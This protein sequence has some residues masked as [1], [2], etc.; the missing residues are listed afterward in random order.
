MPEASV[1]FHRALPDEADAVRALVVR[2]MGYRD[3]SPEYL[4]EASALMELSGEDLQRDE[5]WMAELSGEVAGFYRLSPVDER[6]EI[7]EF[8]LDP[9]MIGH[10][11]GRQM[12]EHAA[13]RARA[14]GGRWL[15]WRSGGTPRRRRPRP[16]A[17]AE[18]AKRRGPMQ[19][20]AH[21]R[22]KRDRPGT[23]G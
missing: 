4:E 20:C 2:S 17:P 10:G 14:A 13:E 22:S 7:E 23:E 11:I 16:H 19:E 5:A 1:T 6:F 18:L 21:G 12:F 3:H 15:V 8:H 9:A